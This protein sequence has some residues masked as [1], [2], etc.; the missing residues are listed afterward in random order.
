[1][2]IAYKIRIF[3]TFCFVFIYHEYVEND[4]YT[5][6][7][8]IYLWYFIHSLHTLYTMKVDM[9]SQNSIFNIHIV[10][11]CVLSYTF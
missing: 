10:V 7:F 4:T 2:N 1:M 5:F 6:I 11:C 9:I 3:E 8:Y